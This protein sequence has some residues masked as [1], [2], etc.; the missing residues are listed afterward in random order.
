MSDTGSL[1]A[2]IG[3]LSTHLPPPAV[4]AAPPLRDLFLEILTISLGNL[5]A[6][7]PTPGTLYDRAMLKAVC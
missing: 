7:M 1:D 2:I 3:E 6:K 4:A 5:Y